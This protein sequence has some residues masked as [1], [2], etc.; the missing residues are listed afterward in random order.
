MLTTLP[1]T[2]LVLACRSGEVHRFE[3][4]GVVAAFATRRRL[5]AMGYVVT[6]LRPGTWAR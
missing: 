1:T 4:T 6:C 3:R 5:A 2:Y